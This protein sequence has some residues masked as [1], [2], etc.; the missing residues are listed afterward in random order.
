MLFG[1]LRLRVE[2]L[3]LRVRQALEVDLRLGVVG[4]RLG[5]RRVE[6]QR[7]VEARER[8]GEAPLVEKQAALA[9]ERL[10][11]AR[12]ELHGLRERVARV[13]RRP[14]LEAHPRL[15]GVRARQLVG[16]RLRAR[17]PVEHL[18][19]VLERLRVVDRRALQ[20]GAQA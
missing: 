15:R 19:Q 16:R 9:V 8:L 1:K 17:R 18:R 5:R 7:G 13:A 3:L 12:V 4:D 6:L 11:V 20:A 14:A 10:H 2:Q